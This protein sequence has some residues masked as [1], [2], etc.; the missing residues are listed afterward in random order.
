[1]NR[2]GE[3]LE[4]LLALMSRLRD[5]QRGCPWDRAQTFASIAPFTIEE[6][7]E[8]ADAIERGEP[9]QLRAELGD[10][11]FQIVFHA[12]LAEE[13]N[14]FGFADVAEGIH[15]KLAERHPHVFGKTQTTDHSQLA[16]S[17]EAAKAAE[18]SARGAAGVLA[19]VPVNLPALTRAEKLTRRAAR[20]GF[21]WPDAQAVVAKIHE[22]IGEVQDAAAQ[23]GAAELQ[24]E[25]GDLLFAVVNWARHHQIDAEA[26][27]RQAGHKFERRFARMEALAGERGWPLTELS[28]AQWEAL[29]SEAKRTVAS[30]G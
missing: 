7:Y 9:Q 22:E 30:D 12:R 15:A 10:L 27:L 19:D 24:A 14:W 18:R 8:V 3:S 21:D 26:A 4:A 11:L 28:F 20:V 1:V 25:I 23:G 5:P 2:A 29:W 16:T 13:R 6:A 17:W